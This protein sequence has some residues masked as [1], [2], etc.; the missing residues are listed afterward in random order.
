[1]IVKRLEKDGKVK[2]MFSSSTV[3]A[4]TYDTVTGDLTVIFNNGGTYMYPSVAKT[5]YTRFE[6]AE[7]TGSEFNTHIK[8]KYSNFKKLD[9]MPSDK[10]ASLLVEIEKLA[11]DQSTPKIEDKDVI[12]G[13]M[14]VI[15]SYIGSGSIDSKNFT[16]LIKLMSDYTSQTKPQVVD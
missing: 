4:S 5:D 3:A 8:K 15:S 7:S 10:I 11:E 1:M 14:K 6:L 13:M 2:A 9:S 12:N 16:D